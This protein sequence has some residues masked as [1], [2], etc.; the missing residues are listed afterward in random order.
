MYFSLLEDALSTERFLMLL[1]LNINSEE[2][3]WN[4][5]IHVIGHLVHAMHVSIVLIISI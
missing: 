2:V 1:Y 4:Y 3:D 5:Y